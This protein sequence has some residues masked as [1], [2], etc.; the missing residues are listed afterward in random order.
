M[1]LTES[2]IIRKNNIDW[3]EIDNI[4]F[5]SKNLYNSALYYIKNYYKETGKFIRYND[6]ER[7]FKL[8]N[9][10][11]RDKKLSKLKGIEVKRFGH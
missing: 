7:E 2:H 11:I 3:K 5:L 9:Q 1:I 8:T 10:V 6:L 4:C